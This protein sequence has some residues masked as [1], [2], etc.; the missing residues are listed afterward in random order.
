MMN[1]QWNG[2]MEWVMVVW[3]ASFEEFEE[4]E[5]RRRL[6]VERGWMKYEDEM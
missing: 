6:W 4:G 3:S 5:E 1:G 2:A